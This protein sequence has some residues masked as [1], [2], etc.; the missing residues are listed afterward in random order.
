MSTYG[1]QEIIEGKKNDEISR[2]VNEMFADDGSLL[3]VSGVYGTDKESKEPGSG[4]VELKIQRVTP[5]QRLQEQLEN[6]ELARQEAAAAE[7][8]AK[9]VATRVGRPMIIMMDKWIKDQA[10]KL[11]CTEVEATK[12]CHEDG[13]W[14]AQIKLFKDLNLADSGN[15]TIGRYEIGSPDGAPLPSSLSYL[16]FGGGGGAGV[17]LDRKNGGRKGGDNRGRSQKGNNSRPTGG[18]PPN[19]WEPDA[20]W[21]EN[22]R[23]W[24]EKHPDWN[25]GHPEWKV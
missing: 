20:E 12:K 16:S 6:V 19:D 15:L 7:S 13:S 23:E 10:K 21:I 11:G 1:Y 25:K 4:E 8:M 18:E 2:K 17:L 14:D 24:I 9:V 22:N 5:S 3:V